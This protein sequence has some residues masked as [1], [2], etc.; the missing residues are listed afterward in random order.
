MIV[1]TYERICTLR[2]DALYVAAVLV[3]D[4]YAKK[5]HVTVRNSFGK[6]MI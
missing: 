1:K 2:Q 5:T 6:L 4:V 3:A